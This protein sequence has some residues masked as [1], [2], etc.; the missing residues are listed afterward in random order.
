MYR[1]LFFSDPIF[2]PIMKVYIFMVGAVIGS[3]L[4][5]CI[6]RIPRHESVVSRRSHCPNC[7]TLICWYQNIPILSY[8]FLRGHCANCKHFIS[9]TYPIVELATGLVFLFLY[10]RFGISMI[11]AIYG[12][13]ACNMIVLLFIDYY[14]RLLPFLFTIPGILIGFAVSFVN[15]LLAPKESLEGIVLGGGLFLFIYV[16]F[17]LIRKKEGMG[18]GDIFLMAMVGAFLGPELTLIVLFASTLIGMFVAL[19]AMIAFRKGSDFPYPFG[20]FI[21]IAAVLAIFFGYPTWWR[22]F[23]H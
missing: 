13:F 15:P 17:R 22:L 2:G 12:F 7:D 21:A 19:I 5:V 11:L 4:N 6:Y 10:K 20:S 16:A 9:P 14:H 23:G 1:A 18:Q 8:L 3:F